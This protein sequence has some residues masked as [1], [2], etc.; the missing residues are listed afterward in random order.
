MKKLLLI[1]LAV[2]VVLVLWTVGQYNSLIAGKANV[3]KAWADVQVQYQRRSDLVPQLVA[4]VSGVANFEKSTLT[5][6]VEARAK[7]TSTTVNPSDPASLEQ[8]QASQT[9]LSGALSRLL[10]TMEAYPQLTAS[11]SFQDLQAQL[12]GTENR[13][14]VAR[15]DFNTAATVWNAST[16][17][18]PKIFIARLFGFEKVAL[19]SAQEGTDKAPTIDFTVK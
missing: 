5:E 14:G 10:V 18:F 12:E 17:Q 15:G 3:D 8:F 19:F 6:V 11:K 2:I 13:I 1:I 9:Q 4:T 16:L 7:A